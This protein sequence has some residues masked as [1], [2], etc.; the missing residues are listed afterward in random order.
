MVWDKEIRGSTAACWWNGVR[1]E[2]LWMFFSSAWSWVKLGFWFDPKQ[3]GC[4]TCEVWRWVN[5]T[6]TIFGFDISVS[7]PPNIP[8]SIFSD[9]RHPFPKNGVLFGE[10]C[11]YFWKC[12]RFLKHVKLYSE[13][14]VW[15]CASIKGREGIDLDSPISRF[16][17]ITSRYPPGN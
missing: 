1:L 5:S 4:V 15:M 16:T 14:V 6:W 8:A 9:V 13:K 7:P 17:T 3:L 12:W 11:R 2:G 10:N